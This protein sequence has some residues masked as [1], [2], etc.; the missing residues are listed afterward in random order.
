MQEASCFQKSLAG[1][2]QL[3]EVV[4]DEVV[5]RK[6]AGVGMFQNNVS[7]T[8]SYVEPCRAQYET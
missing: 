1:E 2:E 5:C 4:N 7:I 6:Y 3:N 8:V